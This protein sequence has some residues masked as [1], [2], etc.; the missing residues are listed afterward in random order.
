[1][2]ILIAEDEADIALSY[3]LALELR[4]HI[5]LV[6]NNGVDCINMYQNEH[7]IRRSGFRKSLPEQNAKVVDQDDNQ[8]HD[9]SDIDNFAENEID[10]TLASN[11]F[12]DVVVL[13]YI[14]PDKDG[15]EVAK[16]ILKINPHQRII[17]ASA[18]VIDTLREAVKKLDRVV[19]LLQKPFT[20]EAFVNTIEDNEAYEGLRTLM[21]NIRHIEASQQQ[22]K[23]ESKMKIHSLSEEQIRSLFEGL[24]KI[25]KYRTF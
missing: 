6:A 21:V 24:R 11:P 9:V 15:M 16:E 25:Q 14:M 4:N 3:K 17:F 10:N 23:E 20:L 2:K 22:Q 19:E 7:Q 18:Y 1:L 12:F 8:S 13:D 5:V